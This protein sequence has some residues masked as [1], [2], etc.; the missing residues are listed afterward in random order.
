MRPPV[1]AGIVPCS[2]SWPSGAYKAREQH[3]QPVVQPVVQTY[4]A[5]AHAQC[6]VHVMAWR[7]RALPRISLLLIPSPHA[8]RVRFPA[9]SIEAVNVA[10]QR[11]V[12]LSC[13]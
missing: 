6:R 10:I 13:A 9:G 8:A 3:L 1:L 4:L 11:A 12:G 5:S 7:G 2:C